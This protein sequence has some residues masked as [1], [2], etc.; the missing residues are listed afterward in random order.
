MN[1]RDFLKGTLAVGAAGALAGCASNGS[2]VEALTAETAAELKWAFEIPPD[3]IPES[4][5]T[6][7]IEAEILIIG[8]GASGLVCANAALENGAAVVL[9]ASSDGPVARGGSNFGI[10]TQAARRA[11]I[12]DYDVSTAFKRR[13]RDNMFRIDQD[14]WWLFAHRSAEALDWLDAKMTAA[15]YTTTFEYNYTDPDEGVLD[16]LPGTLGWVG[17]DIQG[18]GMG[19]P[20]VVN[21]LRESAEGAGGQLFFN[22]KAEQ[23]IREDN[24]KGRVTAAVARGADGKYVKYIGT[25]AVVLATGD[26]TLDKDMLAKY[27]PWSLEIDNGGVYPGDGHKMGLWVGAA[28][29]KSVPNAPMVISMVGSSPGNGLGFPG[30]LVNKYAQRYC[31]EDN[32]GSFAGIVQARQP[33]LKACAIWDTA[34]AEKAAPWSPANYGEPDRAPAQVVAGWDAQAAAEPM[35]VLGSPTMYLYKADT[36][37]EL[38]NK[39]DLPADA[40]LETVAR[41]NGYCRT[42]VDEEFGKRSARLYSIESGPFYGST[43]LPW[44]LITTG[45]LRTNVKLQVLDTNDEVIPGLYAIGTI[46]G[47]MY[48][49]CYDFISP[50]FNLGANCTTFGYVVGQ[51]IAQGSV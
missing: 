18:I 17:G 42:G 46:A 36:L 10:N 50:G 2:T 15:G 27:S 4:D 31:N 7:T 40:L 34:Y 25:K 21:L 33:E 9:I 26:F 6:Q 12:P 38:A 24:N 30:L 37:E 11:G 43:A 3:P 19:E 41:Y 47:D 44:K 29:Q 1:R 45:G 20:L 51:S 28:W 16:T 35:S 49:S 32:L 48:G 39:L 13:M 5:I 8:A 22:M 14:K 23:L